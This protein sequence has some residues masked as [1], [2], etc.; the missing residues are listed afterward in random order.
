MT[1]YAGIEG[2]K[3]L[4]FKDAD[5]LDFEDNI[6][7]SYFI[8]PS[9]NVRVHDPSFRFVN[10]LQ[11]Y[12]G[13]IRAFSAL[14]KVLVEKNKI[15]LALGVFRRSSSPYFYALVPQVW[16]PQNSAH[17]IDIQQEEVL[18]ANDVQE[19]PPGFHMIPLPY[20]D[21]IR[22]APVEESLQ[23]MLPCLYI[24]TKLTGRW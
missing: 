10:T 8:Y 14:L 12:K 6:K 19:R 20:A 23:G 7:H 24:A 15:G 1:T 18:D 9:D 5:T 2:I 17:L 16:F 13:S 22:G 21:D 3:I 11:V 4:G